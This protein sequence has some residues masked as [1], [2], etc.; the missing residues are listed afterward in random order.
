M[1]G[2]V[3]RWRIVDINPVAVAAARAN[4]V[5]ALGALADGVT[6]NLPIWRADS[7]LVPDAPP[8]AGTFEDGPL[9][10]HDFLELHTSLEKPFRIPPLLARADRLAALQRLLDAG[11]EK[12]GNVGTSRESGPPEH[13]GSPTTAAPRPSA[14]SRGS[15]IPPAAG[16]AGAGRACSAGRPTRL[17]TRSAPSCT[18]SGSPWHT[19][20]GKKRRRD[21]EDRWATGRIPHPD[22]SVAARAL[23]ASP[24][25]PSRSG[26]T[27]TGA[28]RQKSTG[29]A[30]S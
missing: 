4:Y 21:E 6:L 11:L 20:T 3:A 25:T 22:S 16:S 29:L 1:S 18:M 23:S 7:L 5:F 28:Y 9:I 13:T 2:S 24:K 14:R 15:R 12:S 19:R 27:R 10:G 8:R 30:T 17:R 26:N